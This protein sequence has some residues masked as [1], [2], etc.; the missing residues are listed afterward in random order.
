[1]PTDVEAQKNNPDKFNKM[2]DKAIE[3]HPELFQGFDKTKNVQDQ[4]QE[5]VKQEVVNKY[6]T[7]GQLMTLGL[8]DIFNSFA[9]KYGRLF[10]SMDQLWL[11]FLCH[12]KC[13][14]VWHGED[15]VGVG[16]II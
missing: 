15:W 5:M 8:L 10:T 9:Q 2:L 11:A 14:E 3:A 4:L 1:M 16:I 7:A 13:G 6:L 12:E